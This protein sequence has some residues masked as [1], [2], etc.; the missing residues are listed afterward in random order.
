MQTR[1]GRSWPMRMT[2]FLALVVAV[3]APASLSAAE[4][5]SPRLPVIDMHVHSTNTQ[6]AQARERMQAMNVRFQ[7]VQIVGPALPEWTATLGEN[8]FLPSLGFPCPGG[9]APYV[10]RRCW[11]GNAD[12][13]DID[14]LRAEIKSGRIKALGEL[15]P[16]L[17]GMQ[18]DDERLQPYW[19]TAEEFDLP[20]AIHMA[21]GPPGAAY[22]TA[23]APAMFPNLRVR[24]GDPLLLEDVLLRHKRLRLLVMHA[25]W[26]FLES[27]IALLYA[28]PNVYV[29]VGALQAPFVM[30]RASYYAYLRGL[31]EAG[32]AK[33][34][35][36]GSDFPNQAQAG[37]DAILAADFLSEAQKSDILCGNAA[38][39]LRMDET[40]CAP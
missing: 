14:W 28:H 8:A 34:I 4:T 17:F 15:V 18:P 36:F 25:G 39:F 10:D 27:T 24:A 6:P 2:R 29:D 26:P 31:V 21:P 5:A 23:Q 16:Q 37:I 40:I 13:P 19:Q 3:S 20:V 12:L 9:R 11:E 38:R 7:F 30:P 22:P 35:V 32:F 1:N 33:R